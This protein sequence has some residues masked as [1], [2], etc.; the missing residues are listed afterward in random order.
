MA[1]IAGS[2]F[3]LAPSGTIDGNGTVRC[4]GNVDI[5]GT[6]HLSGTMSIESGATTFRDGAEF[7]EFHPQVSV[8]CV[9]FGVCVYI[10]LYIS[11]A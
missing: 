10:Y 5:F 2:T 11:Y 9:C 8:C 7:T 6:L 4:N 3:A 1:T